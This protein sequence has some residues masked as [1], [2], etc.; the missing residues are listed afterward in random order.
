METLN[1]I[2]SYNLKRIRDEKNFSLD[3][4]S[5]ETGVSKSMLGQIERGE[6][7]PTVA[8]VWKIANGLKVSFTAMIEPPQQEV[9]MVRVQSV[10]TLH[11][12][13]GK[14]RIYPQF[15]YTAQRGFELYRVEIDADGHLE[16]EPHGKDIE[17]YLSVFS[18]VLKVM[19]GSETYELRKGDAMRFRADKPHGYRND[20]H[21]MVTLS[22]MLKYSGE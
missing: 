5:Q 17:E 6:S 2:I 14:Y 22:M 12:C 9:E 8:T 10:S 13:D 1:S 21:E 16:A 3:R 15:I 19:V 4:V 20:G 11:E 7:N 18:G